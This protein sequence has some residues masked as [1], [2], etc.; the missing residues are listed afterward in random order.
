MT[1]TADAQVALTNHGFDREDALVAAKVFGQ[2]IID[3]S[4][5][6]DQPLGGMVYD[7]W[8]LYNDGM[9]ACRFEVADDG[10]TVRFIGKFRAKRGGDFVERRRECSLEELGPL[11]EEAVRTPAR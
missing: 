1:L 9:P 6:S 10:T 7:V 5:S 2:S 3:E 4:Q 8:G 11:V